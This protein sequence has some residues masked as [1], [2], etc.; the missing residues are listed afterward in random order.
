MRA[1][2]F[3]A[4]YRAACQAEPAA[5]PADDSEGPVRAALLIFW[6][7][8]LVRVVGAVLGHEVFG[9]EATLAAIVAVGVP[10]VAWRV[11]RARRSA[12]LE[13]AD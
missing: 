8:S 7:V 9:A 5:V 4:P 6:T 1:A 2:S 11:C 12:R 13:H 3:G 10:L